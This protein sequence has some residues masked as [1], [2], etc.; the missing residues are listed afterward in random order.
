MCAV[1]HDT[2][3]PTRADAN[4]A[5]GPSK[6]IRVWELLLRRR[7]FALARWRL[8]FAARLRDVEVELLHVPGARWATFGAEAAVQADVFV[9]HH[10]AA[11]FQAILNVKILRDILRRCVEAIAQFRFFAVLR[12]RNAIHRADID[13]C[14][15]L[16]ARRRRKHGL[17]VTVQAALRFFIAEQRIETLF[18]L[19]LDVAQRDFRL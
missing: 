3:S 9:L 15:A 2:S 7:R 19:D 16:D 13:A 1:A 11:G 12:E 10:D 17:H 5:P 4:M 18:N 8:W 6:I 14:I